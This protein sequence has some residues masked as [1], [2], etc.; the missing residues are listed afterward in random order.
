M[1]REDEFDGLQPRARLAFLNDDRIIDTAF[2]LFC[3]GLAIYHFVSISSIELPTW[4]AAGFLAN[5]RA[6][7]NGTP[8]PE[9]FRPPL[10]SWVINGVWTITGEN[11]IAVKYLPAFFTTATAV[12]LYLVIKKHKGS[13]FSMCVTSLTML[14]SQVLFWGEQLMSESISLFFLILSLYLLKGEKANYW[15]LGGITIGLTFASRYPIIIPALTI[16]LVEAFVKRKPKLVSNTIAGLLPTLILVVL[17]IYLKTGVVQFALPQDSNF[18]VY[19]SPY[20]IAN[21]MPIWGWSFLFLPV[22]FLFKKTFADRQNYVY[23]AWFAVAMLFWSANTSNHQDRFA[24]HMLPAAYFLA[25]IGIQNIA[26][27]ISQRLNIAMHG[28]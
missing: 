9:N 13:V 5:A 3:A 28:H 17:T 21:W 2:L 15:F 8:L 14:N 20:Y 11:W 10:L 24:F 4:D 1:K 7:T 16:F 25:L 22:A 6:W 27:I 26:K 18:S 19:L 23:I 12:L